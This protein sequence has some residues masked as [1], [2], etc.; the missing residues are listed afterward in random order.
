MTCNLVPGFSPTLPKKRE[1]V[2]VGQNSG[3]DVEGGG[4]AKK[5]KHDNLRVAAKLLC[6]DEKLAKN[7][8]GC[9]V[10]A[11]FQLL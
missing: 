7:L 2:R 11:T 6:D 5:K 9:N 3:K 10:S 4:K 1:K 8:N